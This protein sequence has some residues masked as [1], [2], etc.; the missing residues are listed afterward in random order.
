ML[1]LAGLQ[2]YLVFFVIALQ[3]RRVPI[4]G[5]H[6]QPYGTWMEQRARNVTDPVDGCLRRARYLIHD[7]DPLST[8]GIGEILEGGGVQPIRFPPKSP[9]LNAYAGGGTDAQALTQRRRGLGGESTQVTVVVHDLDGE[10]EPATGERPEGLFRRGG[11]RIDR[12]AAPS[13]AAFEERLPSASGWR[14]SRSSGGAVTTICFSVII[15]EVR[16][17]TAVRRATLRWRIISTAPSRGL[18]DSAV[19]W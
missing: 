4:A 11:R 16:A 8:R 7:R 15:A 12:A 14:V 5:I 17:L 9:N 13:A 2:R 3:F 18:R 19:D 6:P 10:S 1:T